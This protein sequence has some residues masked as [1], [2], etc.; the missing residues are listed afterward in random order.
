[1][2]RAWWF[3][4]SNALLKSIAHKLTVSLLRKRSTTLQ[5]VYIA[6]LQ[7]I[8]F[9]K[10]NWLLLVWRNSVNF[11]FKQYWN[12]F[13]IMGLMAIPLKSSHTQFCV[14][15]FSCHWRK[16][17]TVKPPNPYRGEQNRTE[18]K[19]EN[20]RTEPELNRNFLCL[21]R[22]VFLGGSASRSVRECDTAAAL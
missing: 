4:L 9:L 17:K 18:L 12:N 10:P 1:M 15:C 20:M 5:T 8:P 3:T 7:P 16:I 22:Q 19:T 6:W 2:K 14:I 13:E 11:S 21:Q